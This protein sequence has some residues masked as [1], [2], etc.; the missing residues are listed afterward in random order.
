MRQTRTKEILDTLKLIERTGNTIG[1][2]PVPRLQSLASLI[3]IANPG[4]RKFSVALLQ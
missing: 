4:G 3:A 2:G 1:Q